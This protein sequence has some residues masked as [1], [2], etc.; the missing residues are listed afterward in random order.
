MEP[1]VRAAWT[2][3]P[4]CRLRAS[5]LGRHVR[6]IAAPDT[7]TSELFESYFAAESRRDA[8]AVVEHFREDAV[9]V[10]PDGRATLVATAA[11]AAQVSPNRRI[12]WPGCVAWRQEYRTSYG[13]RCE[14]KG[15]MRATWDL[16]SCTITLEG[17]LA[18]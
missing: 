13:F 2:G 3:Q 16:H 17:G 7:T 15:S 6:S 8:T 10:L 5:G 14:S 18:A 11:R 12:R 1:G 4:P 9:L